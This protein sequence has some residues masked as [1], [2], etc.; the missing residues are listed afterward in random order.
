MMLNSIRVLLLAGA[1][2]VV[3]MGS[4]QAADVPVPVNDWTGFY[5]GAGGGGAFN[6]ADVGA[7]GYG[8]N[9]WREYNYCYTTDCEGAPIALDYPG[10]PGY[11]E[12]TLWSAAGLGNASNSAS[13]LNNFVSDLIEIDDE[14]EN[15]QGEAGFFGRIEGGF[16]Y[17]IS[18]QF[19]IGINGGFSF[20]KTE[21]SASGGGAAGLDVDPYWP[22]DYLD[23]S[24][25]NGGGYGP[26]VTGGGQVNA[27]VELGNSWSIGG[28]AGFLPMDNVLFFVT[29]GYTQMDTSIS[30]SF[31]GSAGPSGYIGVS[32]R[33]GGPDWSIDSEHSEW[34]DGFYVGGGVETLLTETISLKLEYRYADYGSI[35]T[36]DEISEE[37][38]A[39]MPVQSENGL[40]GSSMGV[41]AE[42]DITVHS[43]F[44]TIN[45]RF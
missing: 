10:P 28:R 36:S 15:D 23:I 6:F 18:P 19:L 8:R 26:S 4:A 31:N 11:T 20:S 9:D 34:L 7:A 13:A 37:R 45:W 1:S 33:D 38:R 17:Q 21:I 22:D 27:D 42:A 29:G 32:G 35:E 14:D 24:S 43:V 44:A 5:I 41:A 40:W 12:Y 30:A 39:V 16:D 2:A 3:V 25:T